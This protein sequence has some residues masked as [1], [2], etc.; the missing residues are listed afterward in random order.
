MRHTDYNLMRQQT[1]LVAPSDYFIKKVYI[2]A[3]IYIYIYV[4]VD[5]YQPDILQPY[6]SKRSAIPVSQV[7]GRI[8]INRVSVGLGSIVLAT[9]VGLVLP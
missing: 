2:Y 7:T 4:R 9:S 3:Y 1:Q 6:T 5:Q 8:R